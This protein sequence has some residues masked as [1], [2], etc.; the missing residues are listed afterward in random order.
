MIDAWPYIRW[1]DVFDVVLVTGLIW[2]AYNWLRRTRSRFVLLGLLL[3]SAVYLAARQLELQLTVWIL[4]GFF[5]VLVFVLV[6]VFQDDLR[7]IFE[8][9][10]VWGLRR[11]PTALPPDAFDTLIRTVEQQAKKRM[12]ALYVIP[13]R[14]P[15]DRHLEGGIELDARISAPLLLSLFDHHSPGH[16]GAVVLA[17]PRVAR[18]AVHLP[19]S[20]ERI[21]GGTRHAAALGLSERCDALAIAVSEERGTVSVARAGRIRRLEAPELLGAEIRSFLAG[22]ASGRERRAPWRE[23]FRRLPEALAAMALAAAMWWVLVPGSGDVETQRQAEVVVENLPAGYRLTAIEPE[24]VA[25]TLSGPRRLLPDPEA[26][27]VHIDADLVRLGRRTFRITPVDVAHPA[28][29]TPLDV[30]PRTVRLA[31]EKTP[32]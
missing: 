2:A 30:E 27:Q 7:R 21:A 31:V 11:R 8:Q 10:A 25:V 1:T 4:Q 23:A 15:L 17:G 26:V 18:F 12:G 9:I 24:S 14:E 6:V 20:I 28:G 13:G 5:A 19:L 29:V 16:D 32:P 3:L 22:V